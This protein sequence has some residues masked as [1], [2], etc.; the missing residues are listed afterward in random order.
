MTWA[1]RTELQNA[2]QQKTQHTTAVVCVCDFSRRKDMEIEV[3]VVYY[4]LWDFGGL[5]KIALQNKEGV[6]EVWQEDRAVRWPGPA[7]R[8]L[9]HALGSLWAGGDTITWVWRRLF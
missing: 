1:G 5:S 9:W 8:R 7:A 2:E 6:W 3:N 4:P